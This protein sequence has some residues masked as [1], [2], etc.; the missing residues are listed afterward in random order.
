MGETRT[1]DLPTADGPMGVYEA[2]P[3]DTPRTAVVVLQEA[4]G[5][6]DHI[7]DVARRFADAGILAVAP[8]LFHRSGS[9][10][11]GYE[12][13]EQAYPHMGALSSRGVE[14]DLEQTLEHLRR[15]GFKDHAIGTVGFC[16]G[17][18]VSL[19]AGARL[20]LGASV[21]FYGGGIL[22]GRFGEPPLVELAP[23]LKTP[24]LGLFGDED[25]GIPVD[26]VEALRE[27]AARAPVTTEVVR[28][29]DAGHGFHCD[30]RDA[31]HA[32]SARD[33]WQR[34]LAFLDEHLQG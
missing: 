29:P 31:F 20:P 14:E 1:V 17:G 5:V 18:T 24:W 26:Q 25:A 9:P 6:N 3:D 19:V 15:L 13:I 32:P 27:A 33:G 23:E 21:T 7:E 11:L 34:T 30:A 10:R 16:M 2:R 28:Y 12:D 22:E 8:A 4:F